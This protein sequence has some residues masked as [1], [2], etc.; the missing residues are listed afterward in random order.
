MIRYTLRQLEYALAI[1]EHGSVAAAA[2]SLGVTQPSL[3]AALQKLED[4][5]GVQVFIRQ[6]AQG[7]RPSP[8]GQ[9]FLQEARGLVAMGEEF[10]RNAGRANEEVEGVLTL[11]SF[12][13]LA[14][15]YAPRLIAEFQKTYP[16]AQLKLVDGAQEQLIAGLRRGEFDFALMYELD[17]PDDLELMRLATLKPYVLLPSNHRLAKL[18]KVPLQMLANEP[19]ILLDVLPSRTYF[20]RLLVS[21][22]IAPNIRFASPSIE[23]VRGMVGQGLGYSLLI[24]R[25]HGDHS[26][27]GS[28]LALRPIRET[29]EPGI[30]AL[31]SLRNLRRTRLISTFAEFCTS[32]FARLNLK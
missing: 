25:P 12:H 3:S 23:L 11:G 10:Q 13:T 27:D 14:P 28:E 22:G 6:H 8:Q 18:P 4:Q 29:V 32:F 24:T 31:A 16:T 15:A 1:A 2:I 17:P 20:T 21:Q 19:L 5:L 7:M 30:I 9:R 26:Y